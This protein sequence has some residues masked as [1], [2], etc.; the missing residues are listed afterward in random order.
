MALWQAEPQPPAPEIAAAEGLLARACLEAGDP[1]EAES[2]AR[3][4]AE[5]LAS[6]GH[7][8][9][10]GCRVTLALATRE[11]ERAVYDEALAAIESA[12]FLTAAEKTRLLEGERARID[13][14]GVPEAPSTAEAPEPIGC[15]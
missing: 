15:D 12:P 8:G 11:R 13:R 1:A 7:P 5:V 3:R 2:L 10:A 6:W 9:A 14:F 4:A